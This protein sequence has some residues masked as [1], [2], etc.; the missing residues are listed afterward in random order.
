M[1]NNRLIFIHADIHSGSYKCITGPAEEIDLSDTTVKWTHV[2]S[3]LTQQNV[4]NIGNSQSLDTAVQH[5]EEVLQSFIRVAGDQTNRRESRDPSQL[6]VQLLPLLSRQQV[7]FIQHQE[8][9]VCRKYCGKKEK[10][11]KC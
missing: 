2:V 7:S 6:P 3:A 4:T 9:P 1:I 11:K 8:K 5:C 10:K